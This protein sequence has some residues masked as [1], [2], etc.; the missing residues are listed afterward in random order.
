MMRERR[1][2]KDRVDLPISWTHP[3]FCISNSVCS[4]SHMTDCGQ[5]ISKFPSD[6]GAGS[7]LCLQTGLSPNFTDTIQCG[8]CVPS[9]PTSNPS[10]IQ[11]FHMCFT[12]STYYPHQ[13]CYPCRTDKQLTLHS[14]LGLHSLFFSLVFR[15]IPLCSMVIGE[16]IMIVDWLRLRYP[17]SRLFSFISLVCVPLCLHTCLHTFSCHYEPP[18]IC[19]VVL[20]CPQSFSSVLN[21]Q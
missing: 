3:H 19:N 4:Q 20:F 1:K 10:M 15:R 12:L 16:L 11:L 14:H 5:S 6:V 13:Q 7:F 21:I 17:R 18:L 2:T 9:S 8:P